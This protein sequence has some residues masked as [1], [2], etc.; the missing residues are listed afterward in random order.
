MKSDEVCSEGVLD[1]LVFPR[2]DNFLESYPVC[3][4]CPVPNPIP[5][6]VALA[7]KGAL[8]LLIGVPDD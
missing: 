8:V 3:L 4:N 5:T 7:N 6:P 1:I 2:T